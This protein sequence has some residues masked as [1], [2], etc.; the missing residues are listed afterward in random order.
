MFDVRIL[1]PLALTLIACGEDRAPPPGG[2]GRDAAITA[3]DAAPAEDSGPFDA[4][5]QV[6][7]DNYCSIA[8]A[9][10][11]GAQQL[12]PD[13]ASCLAA[14][15]GFPLGMSA[16]QAGNS[17]YCRLYHVDQPAAA[18]PVTHCPHAGPSGGGV[19]S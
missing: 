5:T 9:H 2:G 17:L 14:C 6:L 18:D 8:E 10:C 3:S 19:C 15:A 13:R 4:G 11:T 12:Y 7:C 16:D 1:V